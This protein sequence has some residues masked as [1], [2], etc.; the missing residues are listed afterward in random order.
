MHK[1]WSYCRL[2][3]VYI[4]QIDSILLWYAMNVVSSI[5]DS[6]TQKNIQTRS[7]C[8]SIGTSR[9]IQPPVTLCRPPYW[10]IKYHTIMH[11]N[12]EWYC[13]MKLCA[14]STPVSTSSSARACIALIDCQD[15]R[16]SKVEFIDLSRTAQKWICQN[17]GKPV[18]PRI[19]PI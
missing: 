6:P 13:L 14:R 19:L 17:V 10:Y 8:L 9:P 12:P 7:G 1:V 15:S 3:V 16:P 11:W 4:L 18:N 5:T 2:T